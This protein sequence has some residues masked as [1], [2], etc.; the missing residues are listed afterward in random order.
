MSRSTEQADLPPFNSTAQFR[1]TLP[2]NPQWTFGQPVDATPAGKAWVAG[3]E[4]GWDVV[5]AD[6]EDK[7]KLYALMLSGIAPR[8]VAFVSTVSETGVENLAPF[9]WFNMVTHHPPLISIS[10]G[11]RSTGD[12]DTAHNI[13]ATRGFT[14]NIISETWIESANACSI[15]T[16]ADVTEWPLSGL[17]KAD[18]IYVK[19]PRVK[20]SAFS[21]E[22]ELHQAIDITDP[23]TGAHTT[24]LILGRV[25]RIHIRRDVLAPG[26]KR[27]VDPERMRAIS[28]MG[29]ITY[30]RVG[31]GFRLSRP[32]WVE[33][34]VREAV[35]SVAS[36][37]T[38]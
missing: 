38:P 7:M 1:Q 2:P 3:E 14:V 10:S 26:P 37:A 22:C 28:R 23:D 27:A 24:T 29:D 11:V 8:P 4:A 31:E 18:S 13:K 32:V 9:S 34:K 20:E 5:D 17:T 33:D 6:T 15:E 19:A 35:N 12:K 25:R 16:P 21:M 30:A 36:N